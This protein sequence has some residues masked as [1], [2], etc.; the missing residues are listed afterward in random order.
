MSKAP[1]LVAAFFLSGCSTWFV[2]QPKTPW[3]S[4]K[5]QSRQCLSN[6]KSDRELASIARKV[7]LDTPYERDTYFELL[8]IKETPSSKEKVVIGKWASKL[9]SCYKINSESYAYEPSAIAVLSAA[10][11]SEQLSLVLELAKGGLSYGE[12]AVK[13]LEIDTKYRGHITRA[14]SAD[15]KKPIDAAPQ[16]NIGS[17]K[18]SPSQNSSCGWEG[19][20]WVC[21]SL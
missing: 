20:Q 4:L 10:L 15:Y 12:F 1:F 7:T 6:L 8:N 18:T 21:R 16:K 3:E 2:E 17:P 5:Q 19:S 13:R 11:D 9:E 14:I